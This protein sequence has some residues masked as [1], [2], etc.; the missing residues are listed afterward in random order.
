[1]GGRMVVERVTTRCPALKSRSSVAIHGVGKC[2]FLSARACTRF[3]NRSLLREKAHVPARAPARKARAGTRTQNGRHSARI[4]YDN[5]RER[6]LPARPVVTPEVC[7]IAL[8]SEG[9]ERQPIEKTVAAP[10]FPVNRL[11]VALNPF[12]NGRQSRFRPGAAIPVRLIIRDRPHSGNFA[13]MADGLGPEPPEPAGWVNPQL[14]VKR[15]H[16]SVFVS[17]VLNVLLYRHRK[18]GA[19]RDVPTAGK[20]LRPREHIIGY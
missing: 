15:P 4:A 18:Q 7:R 9:A 8:A 10:S 17:V 12:A 11:G 14:R 16:G 1:M 20:S 5:T 6:L 19:P 3:L 2:A 13:V